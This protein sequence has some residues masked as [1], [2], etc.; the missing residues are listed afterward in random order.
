MDTEEREYSEREVNELSA[1]DGNDVYSTLNSNGWQRVIGPSLLDRKKSLYDEFLVATSFE[2][3]LR[4]QQSI[5]AIID[6]LG[7]VEIKMI[8]GKRA[9]GELRENP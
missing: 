3:M 5:K 4:I 8:E 9:L 6:L 7:F 1:K 2:D